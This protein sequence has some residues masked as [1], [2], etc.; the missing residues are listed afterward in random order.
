VDLR[1]KLEGSDSTLA[2]PHYARRVPEQIRYIVIHHSGVNAD[3]SAQSIAAYHTY[4]HGPNGEVWPGIGYSFVVRW[5][6]T[7]QYASDIT[8]CSYHVAKR[9]VE[10]L[11]V[12]LPGNWNDDVPGDAQLGGA[13]ELVTWLRGLLPW[14]TVVGHGEIALPAYPTNCPGATWPAWRSILT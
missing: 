4:P 1:G 11:G 6:G 9:N 13:L 3:S 10:C 2:G 7:I 5:D 8:K 14:A 12:C